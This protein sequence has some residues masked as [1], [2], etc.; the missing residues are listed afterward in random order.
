VFY[1]YCVIVMLQITQEPYDG[2]GLLSP[3][4]VEWS[5]VGN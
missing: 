3:A 4:P 2:K 1:G 5:V